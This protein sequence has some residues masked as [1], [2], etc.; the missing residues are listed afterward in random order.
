MFPAVF[1]PAVSGPQS[2]Y[3]DWDEMIIDDI[4]R[5]AESFGFHFVS[6]PGVRHA[7]GLENI[8]RVNETYRAWRMT[9]LAAWERTASNEAADRE[10]WDLWLA[11]LAEHPIHGSQGSSRHPSLP[12]A[13]PVSRQ[14]KHER[15]KVWREL[16]NKISASLYEW[17]PYGMGASVGA[18]PDEYESVATDLM[19]KLEHSQTRSDFDALA[20]EM[21]PTVPNV[22][23]ADWWSAFSTYGAGRAARHRSAAT[24]RE[25]G[26]CQPPRRST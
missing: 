17:D 24:A 12:L 13:E 26:P 1:A 5:P 10:S 6:Q 4:D 21:F 25:R 16:L 14:A 15:T 7:Q 18:P 22:R 2:Q 9:W 23:L 11:V 3:L 8:V 19:A 20:R